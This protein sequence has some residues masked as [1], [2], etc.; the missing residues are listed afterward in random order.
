MHSG[1]LFGQFRESDDFE[2]NPFGQNLTN[3]PHDLGADPSLTSLIFGNE[4]PE[5]PN[6][7]GLSDF[8]RFT[9]EGKR[10]RTIHFPFEIVFAAHGKTELK[11][12]SRDYIFDN[13]QT[14]YPI[15]SKIFNIWACENPGSKPFVCG[16]IFVQSQFERNCGE[17]ELP[18]QKMCI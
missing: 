2:G 3:H 17:F 10:S 1:D 15:N 12:F 13:I 18:T 11:K 5:W 6:F 7:I 14:F 9:T 8:A 16:E 4:E